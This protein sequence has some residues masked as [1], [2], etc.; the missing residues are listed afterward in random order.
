MTLI[1]TFLVVQ[2]AI[3]ISRLFPLE[4]PHRWAWQMFSRTPHSV[5]FVIHTPTDTT[6][7]VLRQHMAQVRGDIDL[8]G[9]MPAHLC[10]VYDEA[11]RVTWDSGELEC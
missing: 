11:I 1:V 5:Q 3:P 8:T 7:V 10:L 9:L 6:D 2:L 4:T